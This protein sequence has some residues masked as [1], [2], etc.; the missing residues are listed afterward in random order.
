MTK[1]RMQDGLF[2]LIAVLSCL[3]MA[4]YLGVL[5]FC[6]LPTL[7]FNISLV[8][9]I[10]N[11]KGN[12]PFDF[13]FT[14]MMYPNG[15]QVNEG[16]AI[17]FV[18]RIFYGLGMNALDALTMTYFSFFALG[19]F[20]MVY[21]IHRIARNAIVSIGLSIAYFIS[22]FVSLNAGIPQMYLGVMLM[23]LQVLIDYILLKHIQ[24]K[25]ENK[26][27]EYKKKSLFLIGL[28]FL[29]RFLM[30]AVGWY[31][32]VI[33]AVLSCVFFLLYFLCSKESWADRIKQ[34]FLYSIAPWFVGMLLIMLQT[35][36]GT[37]SFTYRMEYFYASS[38]DVINL[39][40]PTGAYKVSDLVPFLRDYMA[41]N[42]LTLIGGDVQYCYLG[43]TALIAL[44]I[45]LSRKDDKRK[46]EVLCLAASGVILL[47]LAIG[48]GFRFA[49]MLSTE[50]VSG[51]A[52]YFMDRE[53][54][55][56]LPW[57]ALYKVFPLKSMRTVY[58]W[59]YGTRMAAFL[60]IA[61]AFG[62]LAEKQKHAEK[63]IFAVSKKIAAYML[64]ILCLLENI[65][66]NTSWNLMDSYKTYAYHTLKNV[67]PGEI[68]EE[69][70]DVLTKKQ[71]LTAICT[72][73]FSNNG[74]L[75][76]YL[77]SSLGIR[78]Y[79]GCGDKAIETAEKL[80]PYAVRKLQQSASSKDIIAYTELVSK[81]KLC[82]YIILPFYSLRDA[83]YY[84]PMPE[85]MQN[86]LMTLAD[87]VEQG[88]QGKY[89]ITKTLHYMVI[90]LT[91]ERTGSRDI[92]TQ[93]V[94]EGLVRDVN[95]GDDRNGISIQ[96]GNTD[97]E[98]DVAGKSTL[99]ILGYMKAS[100]KPVEIQVLAGDQEGNIIG[101]MAES[102]EASGKYEKYEREIEIPEGVESVVIHVQSED[103]KA[104]LD[105]LHATA[106]N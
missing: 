26:S 12:G 45:I 8:G 93:N 82:D 88:L 48:P 29:A 41:E 70:R 104:V 20:A 10:A 102:V 73:D 47:V 69:L 21:V 2:I 95:F 23:P 68:C 17:Y 28:A 51:Y 42:D 40:L 18:A 39:F 99:Y 76:P 14:G 7:D 101:Q 13:S 1:K 81:Q 22:P 65:P 38:L 78:T 92:T 103:T 15:S 19:Y 25:A 71:G 97:L 35:P 67:Y 37:S 83:G 32:A 58:R 85:D 49:E 27:K 34:Y 77:V 89:P 36:T 9:Q 46:K 52:S 72:Y 98:V 79:A 63:R 31:T 57:H 16:F 11:F 84:W 55:I 61:M 3:G 62:K 6:T 44:G 105:S 90:D 30:A 59:L 53:R 74:I 60:L 33:S 4:A 106:Y 86:R 66:Y 24:N 50:E 100:Q 5:P 75:T 87:E 96:E 43:C 80:Y 54:V 94:E 64:V 91:G 56:S